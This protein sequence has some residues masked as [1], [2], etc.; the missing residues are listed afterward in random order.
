MCG[1]QAPENGSRRSIRWRAKMKTFYL[2]QHAPGDTAAQQAASTGAARAAAVRAG[3]DRRDCD[4]G[5]RAQAAGG[6]DRVAD[7]Q[8]RLAPDILS[9]AA[10]PIPGEEQL[11]G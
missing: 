1:T 10:R 6:A 4:L 5:G 3:G 8:G 2:R 11:Q 9:R 7:R